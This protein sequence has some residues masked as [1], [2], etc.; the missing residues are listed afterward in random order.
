MQIAGWWVVLGV[1]AAS[2]AGGCRSVATGAL[3]NALAGTGGSFGRDDDP[4][5]VE[6]AVPFGL[7]TMENVLVE[8]PTHR[9]LLL[10]LASGFTQYGYAFV[11]QEAQRVEDEDF[12][13][14]RAL[15]ARARRLYTRARTYG[16]RGLEARHEG[17]VDQLPVD[18]E[19]ALALLEREDLPLLY[20]TTAAWGLAIGAAELDPTA[21]ADLPITEKMAR[22]ALALDETWG[23][24]LIHE[25]LVNF[26]AA[27][28]VGSLE[29]AEKHFERAVALSGGRRAG[30]FV[31]MAETV[32]VKRQDRAQF[33]R[34]LERALAI[35]VDA[36]PEDR[37]A[38]IIA[39]RRAQRLL[40]RVDDLILEGTA[41]P[42]SA[43]SKASLSL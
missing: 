15:R 33:E 27:S 3:A 24:G 29:Q 23:D 34:L 10:A 20:W 35:D 11:A 26:E 4:E 25:L 41:T 39:Q 16:L 2:G 37:L 1:V 43:V 32:A 18:P 5:L 21:L 6:A 38:N 17:F 8:Q 19:A 36:H 9:G 31:S 13:R 7:K 14:A 42:T 12:D 28:I 30:T 22:R 40:A